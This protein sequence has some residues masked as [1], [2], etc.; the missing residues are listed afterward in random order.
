MKKLVREL[1]SLITR[2]DRQNLDLL[3]VILSVAVFIISA[4]APE[5]GGGIVTAIRFI[6]VK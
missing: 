6:F 4:G 2:I 3:L 1:A 5:S